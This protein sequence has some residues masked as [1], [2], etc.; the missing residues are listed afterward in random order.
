[1]AKVSDPKTEELLKVMLPN[2]LTKSPFTMQK[3]ASCSD[4]CGPCDCYG[5]GGV[6]PIACSSAGA[7]GGV[8]GCSTA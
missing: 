1:M 4:C 6:G 8:L 5:A 3:F 2:F 7:A